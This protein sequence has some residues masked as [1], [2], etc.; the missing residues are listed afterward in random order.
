M[1]AMFV[2]AILFVATV[3][4]AA[5]ST[6]ACQPPPACVCQRGDPVGTVIFGVIFALCAGALAALAEGGRPL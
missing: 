6:Q 4:G 5:A 2:A 3:V 1:H